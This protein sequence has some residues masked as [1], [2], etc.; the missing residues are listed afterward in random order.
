[1]KRQGMKIC[2]EY[3]CDIW[4][5]HV[6]RKDMRNSNNHHVGFFT[7]SLVYATALH[8]SYL[9]FNLHNAKWHH[10]RMCKDSSLRTHYGGKESTSAQHWGSQHCPPSS[11]F[12]RPSPGTR[13]CVFPVFSWGCF[14]LLCFW[15]EGC[16][17]VSEEN[18]DCGDGQISVACLCPFLAGWLWT[19]SLS[20]LCLLPHL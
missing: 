14:L 18:T 7:W 10:Y 3:D 4:T 8:F 12:P 9:K 6:G 17:R 1:M 20:P 2:V 11:C 5:I 19:S 13:V 15:W 16:S